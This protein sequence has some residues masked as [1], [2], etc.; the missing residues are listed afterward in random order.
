MARVKRRIIIR[1]QFPDLSDLINGNGNV[2]PS[3]EI[4]CAVRYDARAGLVA[5][6]SSP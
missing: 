4:E 1:A 6:N 3:R 2:E 5:G